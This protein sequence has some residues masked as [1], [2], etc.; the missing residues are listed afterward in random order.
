MKFAPLLIGKS[1]KKNKAS[2]NL[3]GKSSNL[4]VEHHKI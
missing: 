4:E 2:S 3:E 1:K